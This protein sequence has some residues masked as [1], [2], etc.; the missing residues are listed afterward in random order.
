MLTLRDMYITVLQKFLC[1]I[2]FFSWFNLIPDNRR[3]VFDVKDA[4][5]YNSLRSKNWLH[6]YIIEKLFIFKMEI[7]KIFASNEDWTHDLWFTR[8]TLYHWAI[9]AFYVLCHGNTENSHYWSSCYSPFTYNCPVARRYHSW[10]LIWVL[11]MQTLF[12]FSLTSVWF[13]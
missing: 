11:E 4:F 1:R 12:F 2:C 8:P 5:T 7:R 3:C 13:F 9:E 10:F 6:V